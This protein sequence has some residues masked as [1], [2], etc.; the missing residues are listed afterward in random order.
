MN[1]FA[2]DGR[3]AIRARDRLDFL[4]AEGSALG[5]APVCS[6]CSKYT[7]MIPLASPA[8][9]EITMGGKKWLDL[10]EGSADQVLVSRSL[11]DFMKRQSMAGLYDCLEVTFES[12]RCKR[13]HLSVMPNYV[14]CSVAR[15][16]AAVDYE[17]SII[18]RQSGDVCPECRLG[19]V[20]DYIGPFELET[21]TWSGEDLF[22]ARGLPGTLI[23][24]E[25]FLEA[26]QEQFQL[27]PF[28][29]L[30]EHRGWGTP[31]HQVH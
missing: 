30:A 26:S 7:G 19:P 5:K 31:L 23:A 2:L 16:R 11:L 25:R 8:R 18:D 6:K 10:A 13:A 28:V 9:L 12:I 17:R 20:I 1:F 29:R 4:Q 24:T 3:A 14:L 15:S 22:Y 27:P 21:N